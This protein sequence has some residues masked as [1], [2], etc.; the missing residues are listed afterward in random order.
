M[1]RTPLR[2]PR[3]ARGGYTLVEI[4]LVLAII[5]V[6]VGAGIYKLSGNLD[7]A[8]ET[9]VDADIATITT[10]LKTYEMQALSLPTTEQGLDALVHQPT[11]DP[12][13]ARWHQ[14][15]EQVPVDPWGRPYQY[16][17]PGVHNPNG[18]DLYSL[19]PQGKEGDGNI[20][21]WSK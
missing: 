13:P 2:R 3:H 17:N 1:N 19:G 5:A 4:M 8:K 20:G 15:F 6:L 11:S 7:V 10:Q 18:F 12:V 9:R 16:K 14:L 21:N